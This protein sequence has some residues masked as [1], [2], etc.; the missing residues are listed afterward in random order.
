MS[1]KKE[2]AG[3]GSKCENRF[4]GSLS[5]GPLSLFPL[6]SWGKYSL[7][8]DSYMV[9]SG[10]SGCA[11]FLEEVNWLALPSP[12]R[13]LPELLLLM[14]TDRTLLPW[15]SLS[16]SCLLQSRRESLPIPATLP[17]LQ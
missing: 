10:G 8:Q 9:P 15:R 14:G 12:A 1:P 4:R 2:T 5:G 16:L 11:S 6:S 7:A 13:L 3:Y 17:L